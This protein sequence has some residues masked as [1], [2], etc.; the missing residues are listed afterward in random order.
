[1]ALI[2]KLLSRS[3]G[4]QLRG[5]A[6]STPQKV[7]DAHFHLYGP[8]EAKAYSCD[9]RKSIEEKFGLYQDSVN[10][11]QWTPELYETQLKSSN[12]YDFIKSIYM[13][14]SYA[15]DPA[16]WIESQLGEARHIQHL[17]ETRPNFAGFIGQCRI[18]NGRKATEDWL[19]SLRDSNGKL[20]PYLKGMRVVTYFEGE[21]GWLSQGMKEG[22]QV[23]EDE[24]L[25]WEIGADLAD[26]RKV[27]AMVKASPGVKFTLCHCG[28][29][30]L[31]ADTPGLAE[32]K[33]LIS[34]LA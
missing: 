18:W 22:L 24:N 6:S 19:N 23:L 4:T 2:S 12:K 9:K 11:K 27:P 10:N 13:E 30:G 17:C 1:M 25:I 33:S 34:E 21:E 16:K 5:F 20:S 14:C 7:I 15:D 26:L 29:E 32:W 31:P 28:A 8:A 3:L